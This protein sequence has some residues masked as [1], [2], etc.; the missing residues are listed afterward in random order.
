MMLGIGLVLSG[1][2]KLKSSS[3]A[4]IKNPEAVAQ[5]KS[6]VAEKE[7]QVYAAAK[8]GGKE[9]LPEYKTFFAAAARGKLAPW[10]VTPSTY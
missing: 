9:M 6:F 8:A 10:S 4:S 3:W 1:C 7:V 5:L 2:S